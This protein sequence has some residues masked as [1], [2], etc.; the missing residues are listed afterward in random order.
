MFAYDIGVA[1]GLYGEDAAIVSGL[2]S[3]NDCVLS[4]SPIDFEDETLVAVIKE[5]AR[6]G[7]FAG[8]IF[9]DCVAI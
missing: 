7:K 1:I 8:A 2:K 6:H 9:L 5:G 4:D 3:M